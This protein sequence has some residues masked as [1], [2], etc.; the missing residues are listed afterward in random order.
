VSGALSG[1]AVATFHERMEE[2]CDGRFLIVTLDLSQTTSI[3]SAALG[4]LLAFQKK[5]VAKG[6]TLQIGGCSEGLYRIFQA[7]QFDKL[8]QIRK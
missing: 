6:G 2:L 8:F 1:D 7:I 5:L 3:N 4:K